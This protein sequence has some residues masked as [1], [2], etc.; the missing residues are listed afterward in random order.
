MYLGSLYSIK[1]VDA[2]DS[3][4]R[5]DN[6]QDDEVQVSQKYRNEIVNE[7]N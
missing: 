3:E 2:T 7:V 6:G 1:F 5:W 4:V